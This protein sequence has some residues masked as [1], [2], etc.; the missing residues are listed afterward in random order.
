MVV[1][2]MYFTNK[3]CHDHHIQIPPIPER[4]LAAQECLASAA[5]TKLEVLPVLASLYR[6]VA[7][8]TQARREH[9]CM[10]PKLSVD[11]ACNPRDDKA[12]R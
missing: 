12:W 3:Y 4:D 11:S 8:A 9:G 1:M 7:A 5:A 2:T 6:R 10:G